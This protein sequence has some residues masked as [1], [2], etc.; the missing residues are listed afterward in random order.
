MKKW[1]QNWKFL[2]SVCVF[3]ILYFSSTA[4]AKN[5]N[6][7][8]PYTFKNNTLFIGGLATEYIIHDL[9][10]YLAG[11][12]VGEDI[13]AKDIGNRWEFKENPSNSKKKII[14]AAGFAGPICISEYFLNSKVSRD[15]PYIAG[16]VIAP[17]LHNTLYILGDSIGFIDDKHNDFETMDNAGLKREV[18]YPLA[19]LI[20]AFQSWKF[21]KKLRKNKK[22]ESRISLKV[23]YLAREGLIASIEWKFK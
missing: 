1:W 10:H 22:E 14:L 21:F 9:S 4:L 15:N 7:N 12:I 6:N 13:K 16:I 18:T 2:S 5:D 23:N 11:V 20:P 19:I 3:S 8:S 17:F